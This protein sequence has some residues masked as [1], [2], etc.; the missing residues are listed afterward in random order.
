MLNARA[1]VSVEPYG[2]RR[3]RLG[4]V[5]ALQVVGGRGRGAGGGHTRGVEL[6][7][8]AHMARVVRERVR[9]RAAGSL[10]GGGGG[11]RGH[12]ARARAGGGPHVPLQHGTQAP[13]D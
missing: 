12:D 2:A 1:V 9:G 7:E 3:T 11:A 6:P 5:L 13:L 10:A 8:A 4:G